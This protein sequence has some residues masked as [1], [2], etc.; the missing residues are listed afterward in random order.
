MY[1]SGL[2]LLLLLQYYMYMIVLAQS[3]GPLGCVPEFGFLNTIVGKCY[4][5]C[6]CNTVDLSQL[7]QIE[8]TSS[9]PD[10]VI[11][12]RERELFSHVLVASL[13]CTR[14]CHQRELLSMFW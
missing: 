11:R 10:A 13:F 8:Q 4:R 3:T 1:C 9:V 14:C 2:L 12:V 7:L 5:H 6:T